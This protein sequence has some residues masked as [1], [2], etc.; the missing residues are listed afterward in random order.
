MSTNFRSAMESANVSALWERTDPDGA[1]LF[2]VPHLW[3]W[4]ELDPLI[5]VAVSQTDMEN[6]ERRVLVLE[7]P[8]YRDSPRIG[9]SLNMVVN[10]QVLMPGETARPHRHRLNALR[11]IIEGDGGAVTTVDG[12]RCPMHPGDFLLTPGWCWHEHSHDGKG[13]AVWL[14][15][16]DAQLQR[17]LCNNEFEAGPSN[18]LPPAR[19]DAYAVAGITP[20]ITHDDKPY[21]PIFRYPLAKVVD[22]LAAMPNAAD[23]SRRIRYANPLTGGAAMPGID[24]Y[25]LAPA[26]EIETRAYRTNANMMCL[27]VEG[28]G[29]SQ[30]GDKTLQWGKNDIFSLPRGHWI[31][32]RAKSDDAKL[33]QLTDREVLARLDYLREEFRD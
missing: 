32:H 25:M 16:L 10:L 2:E 30:I 8:A 12:T 3:P 5:D 22:A 9:A 27:A 15:A 23:G 14:D 24:C 28:E 11:F 26:R 21:S 20:V 31:S 18:D 33:F 29:V 13:R 6:A 17:H 7:N 4:A 1:Q 19:S